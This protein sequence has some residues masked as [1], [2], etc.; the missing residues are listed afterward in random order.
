MGKAQHDAFLERRTRI[1]E[2]HSARDPAWARHLREGKARPVR[3]I[4]GGLMALV[5][6]AVAAK[7]LAVAHH[8]PQGYAALVTPVLAERDPDHWLAR[9][10]APDPV[11]TAIAATLRPV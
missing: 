11:T 9:I 6:L 4:F 5:V 7:A 1:L 8:G 10:I 3:A 2:K